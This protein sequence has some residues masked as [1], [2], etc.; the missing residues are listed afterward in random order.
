MELQNLIEAVDKQTKLLNELL[1]ALERE[2]VEMG[3]INI[4]A[5]AVSNR[6]KEELTDKIS[7]HSPTLQKAVATLAKREGLAETTLLRTVADHIAKRG[8]PELLDKQKKLRDTAISVQLVATLNRDIAERFAS[9]VTASL[10]LI[11]RLI[12]QSNVYGSS[13]GYQQRPTGAIM[14]NREV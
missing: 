4:S 7:A 12:N 8:K 11:T 6:S 2:T 5:M 10:N 14:I 13:G 1:Q 9:S 3:E